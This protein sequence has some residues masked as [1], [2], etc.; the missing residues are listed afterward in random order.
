GPRYAR[1][2]RD[3]ITRPGAHDVGVYRDNV[4]DRVRDLVSALDEPT[5]REATA[6]V[7]L[8]FHHEQQHQELLLMDVKHVLS[9]NPLQPAYAGVPSEPRQARHLGWVRVE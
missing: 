6:T 7:E 3:L 1:P 5:L 2:D 9:R 4:D 8:G